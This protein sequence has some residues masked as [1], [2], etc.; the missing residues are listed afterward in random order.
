MKIKTP[1]RY[2][3]KN[4]PREECA[5]FLEDIKEG[6]VFLLEGN[7]HTL[8]A[9]SDAEVQGDEVYVPSIDH[10]ALKMFGD[11]E[12]DSEGYIKMLSTDVGYFG[13]GFYISAVSKGHGFGELTL[14]FRKNSQG[15]IH[16]V[17]DTECWDHQMVTAIF[18]AAAP[19]L[20]Q[21]ALERDPHW[22]RDNGM[23]SLEDDDAERDERRIREAEEELTNLD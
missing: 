16:L 19:Q 20:A 1:V 23:S 9:I 15:K 21:L 8:K 6:D 5:G 13:N 11:E 7:T 12:Y 10:I 22:R 4:N 18:R 3:K 17:C 2:W 14:L